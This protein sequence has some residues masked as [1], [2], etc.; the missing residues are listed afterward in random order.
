MSIEDID[1]IHF[2]SAPVAANYSA[3][4]LVRRG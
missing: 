1:I 2:M 3:F 4:V